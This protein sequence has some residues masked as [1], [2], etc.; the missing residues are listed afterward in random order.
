MQ[1]EI[2]EITDGVAKIVWSDGSFSYC[3]LT[4]DMTE[5]DVDDAVYSM[6][7]PRLKSGEKPAHLS[8]GTRT[9]ALIDRVHLDDD[10]RPDYIIKRTE[11]YGAPQEQ[12]EFITENGLDAWI[13][14]VAQ[15]KA[16]N[17]KT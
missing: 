12:L 9:A 3:S 4:A 1:Y 8:T 17:P 10:V 5:A 11:A 15:I 2:T 13:A 16:D 6:I 7:P 14:K